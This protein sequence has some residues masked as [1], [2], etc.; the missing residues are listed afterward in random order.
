MG[1]IMDLSGQF[2][3]L[4]HNNKTVRVGLEPDQ[5]RPFIPQSNSDSNL[6]TTESPSDESGDPEDANL[7]T[8]EELVVS[9]AK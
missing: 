5:G 8:D 6:F 3:D 9:L 2:V 7:D 4:T 1:G